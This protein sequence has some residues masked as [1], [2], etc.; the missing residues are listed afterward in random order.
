MDSV[1]NT[2]NSKIQKKHLVRSAFVGDIDL[3]SNQLLEFLENFT[4]E[5]EVCSSRCRKLWNTRR[6]NHY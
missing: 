1:Y 2:R 4:E 6:E 3:S 5:K